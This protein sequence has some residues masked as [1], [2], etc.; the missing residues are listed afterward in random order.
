MRQASLIAAILTAEP[1][2]LA[3]V[4]PSAP[5]ALSRVV[6]ICL[7]KDPDDRWQTARDLLRELQWISEGSSTAIPVSATGVREAPAARAPSRLPLAIAAV[8]FL[9][10]GA[11]LAWIHFRE[12]PPVERVL[13][14]SA[15][16][17]REDGVIQLG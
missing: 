6:K 10:S 16:F 17:Q 8:V 12:T 9:L 2:P 7:S 14:Y 11:V 3:E 4:Q 13:R 5:P 1:K 15:D